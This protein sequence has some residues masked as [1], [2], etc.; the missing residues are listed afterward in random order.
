MQFGQRNLGC[1][2]LGF[3]LVVEFDIGWNSA[4]VVHHRNRIVG[5]DGDND[6]VAVT[7]ER[8]ID[9][10]VDHLEHQMM[11]TCAIGCITDVHA[12]PLANCF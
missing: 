1:R 8:F 11:Q 2:T 6:V 4:P 3:V 7:R 9:R 5:M 10:V 12:R